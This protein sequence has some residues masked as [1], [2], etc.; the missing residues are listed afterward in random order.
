M[1]VLQSLGISSVS[2]DF[3]N[4]MVRIS[5]IS[6]ARS[7]STFGLMLS[8]PDALYGLSFPSNFWILAQVMLSSGVDGYDP[9][10]GHVLLNSSALMSHFWEKADWNWLFRI[11]AWY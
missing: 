5:A 3:F 6:G 11:L 4:I 9:S 10:I 7:L 8:G 2:S 1:A